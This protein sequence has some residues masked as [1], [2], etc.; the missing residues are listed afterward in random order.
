MYTQEGE[1]VDKVTGQIVLGFNDIKNEQGYVN[2]ANGTATDVLT[3]MKTDAEERA[4]NFTSNESVAKSA[5]ESEAGFFQAAA[6]LSSGLTFGSAS[7]GIGTALQSEWNKTN[8]NN[9]LMAYNTALAGEVSAEDR[10]NSAYFYNGKVA[11]VTDDGNFKAYNIIG[12]AIAFGQYVTEEIKM[13]DVVGDAK[14]VAKM[15]AEKKSMIEEALETE[16]VHGDLL[17][18]YR[19]SKI[20]G[21]S[22][23]EKATNLLV[24]NS[25]DLWTTNRL[26]DALLNTA[27]DYT[28]LNIIANRLTNTLVNPNFRVND[29]PI[30]L[31]SNV[32]GFQ[33]EA[34]DF[35]DA[36]LLS[37]KRIQNI[38]GAGGY[39]ARRNGG[40]QHG[41]IDL[42]TQPG[43]PLYAPNDGVV[44]L[45]WAP[46][47]DKKETTNVEGFLLVR[48]KNPTIPSKYNTSAV[49]YVE[50]VVKDLQVVKKG[51]LIGYSSNLKLKQDYIAV[52]NHTHIRIESFDYKHKIN[53][54]VTDPTPLIFK[55]GKW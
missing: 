38:N 26:N 7:G 27:D 44:S 23:T 31:Y 16:K 54:N 22:I 10:A 19:L 9:V 13:I 6:F 43:S 35:I 18:L 30:D 47:K 33:T 36:T 39:D 17:N 34:R 3:F 14:Q 50:P 46:A 55:N 51:Q 11:K 21:G 52:P 15:S 29:T 45:S 12:Y 2:L 48:I 53:M 20:D 28:L 41:A 4:H 25:L 5:A 49:L 8:T 24:T 1:V 42:L 40:R 37:D 32:F